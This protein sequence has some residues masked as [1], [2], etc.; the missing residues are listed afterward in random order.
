MV[1][2]TKHFVYDNEYLDGITKPT[3]LNSIQYNCHSDSYCRLSYVEEEY[4]QL[5]LQSDLI[6]KVD[7]S[8]SLK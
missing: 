5:H 4:T 1:C 2:I 8:E 7:S 3:P 6:K